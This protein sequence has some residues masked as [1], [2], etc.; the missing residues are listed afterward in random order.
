MHIGLIGG[1]GPAA[2]VAYYTRLVAEF[3]KAGMPLEITIVHAEIATLAA[4]AGA[5]KRAEQAAVFAK[6]LHQLKGAG[7]DIATITALTG[8]F[9]FDETNQLSPLP[10][11]NAIDLVDN[12]C[13]SQNIEIL[14]LLGSPPV[15]TTHLF[16]LLRA[17]QT[18]VPANNVNE[19]GNTY[20]E[21]ANA[22]FCTEE[23]RQKLFAAGAAMM[24]DQN[25]EA[26]L[27][28]GTDLGLAFNDHDPGYRVVDALEIHVAALVGMAAAEQR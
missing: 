11:I 10:L 1:I 23:N 15:L 24:K 4:N 27:L 9:C 2:T 18:V 14:G 16:G 5:D 21:I 25:A 8:H 26:I 17:P 22:G 20:M 7:C 3:K 13:K 28:A 6:H 19:L 12:Y